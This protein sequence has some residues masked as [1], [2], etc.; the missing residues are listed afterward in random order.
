MIEFKPSQKTKVQN[1]DE[2]YNK[3]NICVYPFIYLLL[4]ISVFFLRE[5]ERLSSVQAWK[6][7]RN[8]IL[9]E[10]EWVKQKIKKKTWK[11]NCLRT[12]E[13][14]I[15]YLMAHTNLYWCC[16]YIVSCFLSLERVESSD[17]LSYFFVC[18]NFLF[19]G[20]FFSCIYRFWRGK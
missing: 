12:D 20:S 15:T 1:D 4:L 3:N 17:R 18:N 2:E 14:H 16:F 10:L 11:N 5:F 19:F 8:N 9:Y 7:N 6:M 13:R